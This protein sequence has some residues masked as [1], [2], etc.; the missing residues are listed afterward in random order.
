MY[1]ANAGLSLLV[2]LVT[3]YRIF[4]VAKLHSRRIGHAVITAVHFAPVRGPMATE[5]SRQ[6]EFKAARK[7]LFVIGAFL[8]CLAPY[9]TLRILELGSKEISLSHAST[10]TLRWIAFLKSAI[11]PFIYGLLQRRFRRS[12]LELFLGT[13]RAHLARGSLPCGPIRLNVRAKRQSSQSET[14]TFVTVTTKRTSI[15]E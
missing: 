9:T 6:R 14:G 13:Q 3:Y 7:I 15:E 10:I 11:D 12:L 4:N 5:T 2:M 8:C 1:A